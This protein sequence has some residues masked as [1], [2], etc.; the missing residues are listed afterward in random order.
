MCVCVCECDEPIIHVPIQRIRTSCI[1]QQAIGASRAVI[2]LH[3]CAPPVLEDGFIVDRF[4]QCGTGVAVSK[5]PSN[6]FII[7]FSVQSLCILGG[8]IS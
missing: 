8:E 3:V 6:L 7:Q 1:Q 4:R 5:G 2:L